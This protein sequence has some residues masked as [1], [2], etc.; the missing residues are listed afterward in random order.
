MAKATGTHELR[1]CGIE[2]QA[3]VAVSRQRGL[4]ENG[5]SLSATASAST[6]FGL[7]PQEEPVEA[8]TQLIGHRHLEG[9]GG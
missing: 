3:A 4:Q 9:R 5:S 7:T 8:A 2:A 1:C 6:T